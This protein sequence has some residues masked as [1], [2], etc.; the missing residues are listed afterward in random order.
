MTIDE[1]PKVELHCHLDGIP[2]PE[3]VR[4]IRADDSAFPIRPEDF[5]GLYPVADFDGF[6]GWWRVVESVVGKL[7]HFHAVLAHYINRLK[8]DRVV[9]AEVMISGSE[10]PVDLVEAVE[11]VGVFRAAA[12]QQAGGDLQIE[13]L[14]AFGRG[15]S[16]EQVE[17]VAERIFALYEAGLVVGVA[18]A[19]VEPGNPVRPYQKTF[20]RFH[21]AGLGIEIHAG[22]WCGPESG[23]DAL[24]H[25]FPD[26][27]GHGVRLFQ[28]EK[29]IETIAERGIHI[30]MCPTSN[31]KTG[32]IERIEDHPIRL[33]RDMGLS[34]SINTDDPGPF[35]CSMGSECRL[36]SEMFGFVEAD[37]RTIYAHSL[38]ARFQ[39]VLTIE[40]A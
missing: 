24:E 32:S 9:Y 5:D 8:Q 13:F 34:F 31:L 2:D 30:E 19:G 28:D 4:D 12:Q 25:G 21:E 29:L 14:A 6:I 35:E 38:A 18:L 15:K 7:E 3:M 36:L 39:K 11:Q 16:P 33:A 10:I 22:E 1:I 26:R 23:W 40:D 20:E 37:F 17:G 27:I